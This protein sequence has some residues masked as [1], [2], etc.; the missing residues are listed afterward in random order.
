MNNINDFKNYKKAKVYVEHLSA[1]LKVIDL[2]IKGLSL[3][4]IYTPCRKI[5]DVMKEEK[6]VLEAY[7]E[8]NKKVVANKG[9]KKT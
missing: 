9:S 6:K 8:H 1:S 3:F 4:S 2:S 7:L 5:L